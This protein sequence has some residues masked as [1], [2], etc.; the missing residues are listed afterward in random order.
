MRKTLVLR[1]TRS[2]P[3]PESDLPKDLQDVLTQKKMRKRFKEFLMDKLAIESLLFYESLEYYEKLK[4]DSWRK[5]AGTALMNK[6]VLEGSQYQVNLSGKTRDFIL[7]IAQENKFTK[8]TF[9]EAKHEIYSLMK[10]NFLEKFQKYLL[11]EPETELDEK[12]IS[13]RPGQV[14]KSAPNFQS[15]QEL[16]RERKLSSARRLSIWREYEDEEDE[17][18]DQLLDIV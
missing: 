8:T 3:L 18:L 6:F 16:P 2:Q 11:G 5:K 14:Y 13:L 1:R 9:I 10:V 7:E 4:K 15:L 12:R 17:E